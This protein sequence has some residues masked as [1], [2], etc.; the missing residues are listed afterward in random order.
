MGKVTKYEVVEQ[1][2]PANRYHVVPAIQPIATYDNLEQ[3]IEEVKTLRSP[4]GIKYKP[5]MEPWEYFIRT[6]EQ[7]VRGEE[8]IKAF[9]KIMQEK[10]NENGNKGGWDNDSIE[11]LFNLLEGEVMELNSAVDDYVYKDV[12]HTEVVRECADVANYA[13]M[14]V[15]VV[16]GGLG[17]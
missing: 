3:A 2:T 9:A 15:D 11:V 14:I 17:G 16:S 8:E 1:I 13:M 5:G 6:V 10:L 4:D 7:V 12:D